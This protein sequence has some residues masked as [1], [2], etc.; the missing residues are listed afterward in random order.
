[1]LMSGAASPAHAVTF[2]SAEFQGSKFILEDAVSGAFCKYQ[3]ILM[4][5]DEE[6][7]N[8]FNKEVEAS[9]TKRRR[10]GTLAVDMVLLDNTGPVCFA[11]LGNEDVAIF[12][13]ALKCNNA[14]KKI[15]SLSV[16]RIAELPNNAWNGP[17]LTSLRILKTVY[18]AGGQAGTEV[19]LVETATSPFLLSG[20]YIPPSSKSCI[21][22]YQ[23]VAGRMKAPFRGTFS[24]VV[25]DL[26]EPD[27]T[28]QG[29]PKRLFKLLDASGSYLLCCA[30]GHNAVSCALK[31]KEEIVVYFGTGRAPIG[32][33]PG[34][35]YLMKDSVIVPLGAKVLST[36][37]SKCVD[38][39]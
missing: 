16:A 10:Q 12:L 31:D 37:P 22:F 34:M 38:I 26:Q 35:L 18:T 14:P 25:A 9:P 1:M 27:V 29:N 36:L 17:S 21:S 13:Q 30:L 32:S 4:Y 7:R 24:G 28:Q 8:L 39:S 6:P 33:D 5:C 19:R 11:M 2:E 20:D 15:V 3:G 23:P